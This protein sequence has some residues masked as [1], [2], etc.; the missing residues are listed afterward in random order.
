MTLRHREPIWYQMLRGRCPS[1]MS[2]KVQARRRLGVTIYT[3]PCLSD[4]AATLLHYCCYEVTLK[5][6]DRQRAIVIG[7][8][9]GFDACVSDNENPE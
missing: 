6:L 2:H 4:Q 3:H 5:L 9:K 1:P 8:H 7:V